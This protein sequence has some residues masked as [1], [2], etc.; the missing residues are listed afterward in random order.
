MTGPSS[1]SK[2]QYSWSTK[3]TNKKTPKRNIL[4]KTSWTMEETVAI[5]T[6]KL[7]KRRRQ[8]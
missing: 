3:P 2:Y 4:I 5:E 1:I 7:R 8:P 6:V